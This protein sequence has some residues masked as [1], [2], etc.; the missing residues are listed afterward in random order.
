MSEMRPGDWMCPSC[1]NHNYASRTACNRCQSPKPLGLVSPVGNFAPNRPAGGDAPRPGDWYCSNPNC[2][3]LNF[4]SRVVCNRCSSPPGASSQ[5]L[6]VG[7]G[8]N[9]LGGG[10]LG[11][12]IGQ[13]GGL[14][15]I[16]GI[17]GGL[18][19]YGGLGGL[20]AG[21]NANAAAYLQQQASLWN[22]GGLGG[23]AGIGTNV[24]GGAQQPNFRSGDWI[25][26]SC[27]NH[28]Y[29]SRTLCNRCQLPKPADAAA[30]VGVF[31]QQD[32]QSKMRPGDWICPEPSCANHNYAS[33]MKCNKCQRP[34]PE[35]NVVGGIPTAY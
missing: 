26:P 22:L 4:A 24:S 8:M 30:P 15:G 28:N 34:K 2:R 23:G 29:A 11:L 13:Q 1:S 33:R 20:G 25:C 7:G 6:G 14:G 18:G 35:V 9:T 32:T 27:S 3:N 10:G 12:G 5:P 19:G 17:G 16:V 21:L 31:G